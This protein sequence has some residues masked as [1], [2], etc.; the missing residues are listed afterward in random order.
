MKLSYLNMLIKTRSSPGPK[1][2][3]KK[4]GPHIYVNKVINMI[5]PKY[6]YF[7]SGLLKK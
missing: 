5:I 7:F 4:S 2:E 3:S 1:F 6:V